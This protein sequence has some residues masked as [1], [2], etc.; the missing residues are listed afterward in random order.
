MLGYMAGEAGIRAGPAANVSWEMAFALLEVMSETREI[1][2]L[3]RNIVVGRD[4]SC[5]IVLK[6]FQCIVYSQPG[7][8]PLLAFFLCL[9]VCSLVPLLLS[10]GG[11]AS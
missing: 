4:K 8:T 1:I 11:E 9:F 10:V 5:T 6:S 2:V 7:V 3:E